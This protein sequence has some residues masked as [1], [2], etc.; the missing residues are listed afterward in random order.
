MYSLPESTS[1]LPQEVLVGAES[2]HHLPRYGNVFADCAH[3]RASERAS[4]LGG[5]QQGCIHFHPALST[6]GGEGRVGEGRDGVLR[7]LR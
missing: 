4:M 5:G 7:L 6:L 2:C 1:A 3:E